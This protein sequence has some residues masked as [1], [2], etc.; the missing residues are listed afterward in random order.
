MS[1]TNKNS[2]RNV[3]LL[4]HR[5]PQFAAHYTLSSVVHDPCDVLLEKVRLTAVE[6]TRQVRVE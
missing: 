6:G 5:H 2:G 1:V 3:K 4:S